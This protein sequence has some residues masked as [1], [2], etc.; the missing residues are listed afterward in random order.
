MSTADASRPS[1]VAPLLLLLSTGVLLGLSTNLAKLAGE[2]SL[3]PMAFLIWSVVG[4]AVVLLLIDTIRGQLPPINR[5]TLEY[6][7]VSGLVSV[8][9]SN[10]ILFA[11]VPRVGASFVALAIAFPPL[12]TYLGALLLGLESL[13][14]RRALGVVLALSGAALLAVYKLNEPDAN[15]FWIFDSISVAFPLTAA[16]WTGIPESTR[17]GRS[18]RW[19]AYCGVATRRIL[20][21]RTIHW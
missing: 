5:Q 3:S 9:L 17:L 1:W 10:L 16:G 7:F 12:F 2:A 15:A 20:A 13:Q 6:F 11:A 21:S 18:Y 8:A 14:T 19:S 4:A